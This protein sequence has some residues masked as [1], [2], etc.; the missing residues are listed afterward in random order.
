[1]VTARRSISS[2]VP[3][4]GNRR[5]RSF[6]LISLAERRIASIGCSARPRPAQITSANPPVMIGTIS[7]S[8]QRTTRI[9]PWSWASDRATTSHRPCSPTGVA[10]TRSSPRSGSSTE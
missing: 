5:V 9:D 2:P 1:M 10:R 6:S 7:S 3:G 4:S 8:A